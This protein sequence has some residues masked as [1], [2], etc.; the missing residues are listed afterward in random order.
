[1]SSQSQKILDR[2]LLGEV[3]TPLYAFQLT[4]SLCAH[5]RIAEIRS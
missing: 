5:S 1:M 2:L 3:I 4:G